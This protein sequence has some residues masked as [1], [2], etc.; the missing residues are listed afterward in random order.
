MMSVSAFVVKWRILIAVIVHSTPSI[1]CATCRTARVYAHASNARAGRRKTE[2]TRGREA[3]YIL[4][5]H[6]STTVFPLSYCPCCFP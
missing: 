1:Y 3:G 4:L 6:T 5:L 2:D